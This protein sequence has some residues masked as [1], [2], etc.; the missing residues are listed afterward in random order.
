MFQW[1]G[2]FEYIVERS[3]L[4]GLFNILAF[5]A[6]IALIFKRNV[7]TVLSFLVILGFFAVF[8][9]LTPS[10]LRSSKGLVTKFIQPIVA[11]VLFIV[12]RICLVVL[13]LWLIILGVVGFYSYA[14]TG[15]I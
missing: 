6:L 7:Y 12:I 5:I 10:F 11:T 15:I 14:R 13:G 2:K 4:R 3:R 9:G 1:W 8:A